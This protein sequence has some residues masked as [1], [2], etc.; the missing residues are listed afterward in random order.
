MRAG[1]RLVVT[2]ELSSREID[3]RQILTV[4]TD[5]STTEG[6]HVCTATNVMVYSGPVTR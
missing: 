1:D 2:S 4:A 6:E 3:G 5:V